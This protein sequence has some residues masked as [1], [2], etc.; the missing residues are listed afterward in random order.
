MVSTGNGT[1][2]DAECG[3]WIGGN[4][5]WGGE[6]IACKD[7]GHTCV[8][9]ADFKTEGASFGLA[10]TEASTQNIAQEIA[11]A[12]VTGDDGEGQEDEE[13]AILFESRMN[14]EDY[15]TDDEGQAEH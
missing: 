14:G 5:G 12:V 8:L 4:R 13:E 9:H 6:E 2:N 11:E 15:A 7:G 3:Q 10:E 1:W